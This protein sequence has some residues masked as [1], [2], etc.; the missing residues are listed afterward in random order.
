ML[1]AARHIGVP[2]ITAN[3]FEKTLRAIQAQTHREFRV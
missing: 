2:V 1:S 3:S